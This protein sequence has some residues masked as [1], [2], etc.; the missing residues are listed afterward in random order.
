LSVDESLLAHKLKL[1][2]LIKDH[3]IASVTF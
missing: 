1:A 2:K 3:S